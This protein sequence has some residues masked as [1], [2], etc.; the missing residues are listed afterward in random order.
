MVQK[1]KM[2]AYDALQGSGSRGN[3]C[4]QVLTAHGYL[5][6][7]DQTSVHNISIYIVKW[8]MTPNS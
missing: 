5:M 6:I 7:L 2:V 8:K 3:Q 1:K 4:S